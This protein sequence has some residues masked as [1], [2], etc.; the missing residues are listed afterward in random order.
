MRS[1]WNSMLPRVTSPCCV[2]SKPEMALSVVDFARAVRAQQGDNLPLADL[3]R[4]APQDQDHLVI[5]NF[6]KLFTFNIGR[7]SAW[8]TD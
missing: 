4:D 1:P 7:P 5:D 3:Q 8:I 2:W 6:D